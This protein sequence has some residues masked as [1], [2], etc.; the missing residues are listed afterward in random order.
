VVENEGIKRSL[1]PQ[2]ITVHYKELSIG[3]DKK[4]GLITISVEAPSTESGHVLSRLSNIITKAQA[5]FTSA[6]QQEREIINGYIAELGPVNTTS[7]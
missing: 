6:T 3:S 1:T 5:N 7:L 2:E 4:S